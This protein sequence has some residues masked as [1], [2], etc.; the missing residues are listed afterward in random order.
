MEPSSF[1]DCNLYPNFLLS[2]SCILFSII[3]PLLYVH[4]FHFVQSKL[5]PKRRCQVNKQEMMGNSV[6][7]SEVYKVKSMPPMLFKLLRQN[8]CSERF[9]FHFWMKTNT[10]MSYGSKSLHVQKRFVD[11]F[12]QEFC[13]QFRHKVKI[14][15]SFDWNQRS[16]R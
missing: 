8:P 11:Y 6:L 1:C 4:S 13:C 3:N 16:F 7:V 2:S 14:W 9:F 10:C 15:I 5:Q 12:F